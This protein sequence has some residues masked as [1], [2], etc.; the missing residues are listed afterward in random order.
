MD[1]LIEHDGFGV[2]VGMHLCSNL[3]ARDRNVDK[4][5][6]ERRKDS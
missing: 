2:M 4:Y 6:D 5:N 3:V 1:A